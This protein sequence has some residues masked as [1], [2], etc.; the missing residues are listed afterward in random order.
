MPALLILLFNHHHMT[1]GRASLGGE[2]NPSVRNSLY[3]KS[4]GPYE[5]VK[6]IIANDRYNRVI[7]ELKI[8]YID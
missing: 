8:L 4:D 2:I 5:Q 3:D 1:L 6:N 7:M